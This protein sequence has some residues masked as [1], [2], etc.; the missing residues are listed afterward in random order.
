MIPLVRPFMPPSEELMPE[1]EKILY[2][3]YIAE[4]QAV[5]DFEDSFKESGSNLMDLGE[6]AKE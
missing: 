1:I 3:G 4:G 6:E 5:Y 2:S